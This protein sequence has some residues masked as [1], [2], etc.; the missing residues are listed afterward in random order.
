M[1]QTNQAIITDRGFR[2]DQ[3]GATAVEF[4]FLAPVLI[5]MPRP[6]RSWNAA[7]AKRGVRSLRFSLLTLSLR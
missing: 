1:R 5:F 2:R 6:R 7:A 3:S 4:A